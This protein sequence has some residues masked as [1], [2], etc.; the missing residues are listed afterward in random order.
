[1]TAVI[2]TRSLADGS[3][4][5]T[6]TGTVANRAA[7]H[8]IPVT[9]VNDLPSSGAMGPEGGSLKSPSGSYATFLPGALGQG[10]RVSVEDLSQEQI[11]DEYGVDYPALGLTFLGALDIESSA[12]EFALPLQVDLDGWAQAKQPGQQAVVFAL[13]ADA[14]GDG[15]G[16]LLAVADAQATP[17]GSMISRP[18]PRSEVYA[19][20]TSASGRV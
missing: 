14:D 19:P 17:G 18:Q 15:I 3:Y 11:L 16:E 4:T 9:V 12:P 5:L 10:G 7:K 2:D 6:A 1:G 20:G 13:T 8:S